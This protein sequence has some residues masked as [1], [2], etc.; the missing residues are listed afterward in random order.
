MRRLHSAASKC[1]NPPKSPPKCAACLF[2]KQT[3]RPTGAT[4]V[5]AVRDRE[6]ALRKEDL[7]AG[8]KI[9]ADH[10]I[11]STKGRLFGSKGKTKEDDMYSGGCIFVDHATGLIHI[12]L[13]SKLNTHETSKSKDSF[14][15]M[16]RDEGV[17]PQSY[18]TDNGSSFTSKEYTDRL[19][20]FKQ[21]ASFAGVGAHHGNGVAERAI[22][23]IMSV[24]RTMMLHAAIHW[25]EVSDAMYWPMAVQHAVFLYN[26]VPNLESGL[27]PYDLFTRSR[28]PQ[29]RF[30]DIH[31]WGC[32]VYVLDKKISDGNKLPRWKP[33]S[34][35]CIYV[36]HSK[37]HAITAPLVLNPETGSITPQFHVVFDDWFATIPT[38]GTEL[39][40][41]NSPEWSKL[42]GDSV[43]QYPEHDFNDETTP[44]PNQ[45]AIQRSETI[46][47]AMEEDIFQRRQE[48]RIRNHPVSDTTT[49]TTHLSEQRSG[50]AVFAE[51]PTVPLPQRESTETSSL[52][53]DSSSLQT[54]SQLSQQREEIA[55]AAAAA[56]DVVVVDTT[57]TTQTD[58]EQAE[59]ETVRR[60][61]RVR[62]QPDRF[63]F[64]VPSSY[65][66]D[67]GVYEPVAW[68][69]STDP[70]TLTWDEA[71]AS[72]DRDEFVTAATVEIRT[73]EGNETWDEVP[74]SDAKERI[75]PGTWTFKRKRTPDG[76]IYRHKARYCVRGDLQET[77]EDTYAPVVAFST[78][79]LFLAF[80][81]SLNWV[82]ISMDWTNAFTQAKLDDPIWIHV[83]RGFSSKNTSFGRLCLRLKRSLYG[84][85]SAP[86]HWYTHLLSVLLKIGFKQSA[87]DPCLLFKTGMLLVFWV[88]DAAVAAS[89]MEEIDLLVAQLS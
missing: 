35:R 14:E 3:Q 54:P 73:L 57:D 89:R 83:P 71:M 51:T 52:Q 72:E 48:N 42:F 59:T 38:N 36:G 80:T 79:R 19:K 87:Y 15:A 12:E 18:L 41:F 24:A 58:A 43:F 84:T 29:R 2:G 85:K 74:M 23:T 44:P 70:D 45:L 77:Q 20:H 8:Q 6:G 66:A 55:D 46:A 30:H 37:N 9:S 22:R 50:S 49:T 56:D 47:G 78:I 16:C 64:S 75:I 28:W 39:P 13:Q 11:C 82:S 21:T 67:F 60:S 61:T 34:H 1:V 62:R 88:D 4:L 86:K 68:K 76:A 69:A 10:F 32:P 33:R 27:S 31:V 63:A 25:P 53:F 26:H 17:I 40:D 65:I 7:L 81:L 5:Q